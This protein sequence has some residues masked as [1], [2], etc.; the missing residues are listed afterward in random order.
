MNFIGD[1]IKMFLTRNGMTN[2]E[3]GKRLGVSEVAVSRWVSGQRN[4]R[5]GMIDKM[6]EVFGCTHND[7]MA[8][9]SE[10]M[11]Q[12]REAYAEVLRLLESLNTDGIIEVVNY[13]GNLNDRF[14]K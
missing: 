7:L 2:T 3:L 12:D 1:N 9:N 11:Q 13:I 14:L 8:H 10:E 6:C 4:P 5:A